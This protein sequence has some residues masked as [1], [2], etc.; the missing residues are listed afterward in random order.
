M[1]LRTF[2]VNAALL[3][4]QEAYY[5]YFDRYISWLNFEIQTRSAKLPRNILP[6]PERVKRPRLKVK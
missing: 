2:H 1:K 4:E 6:K 5:I 3:A